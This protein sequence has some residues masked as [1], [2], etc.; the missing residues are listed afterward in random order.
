MLQKLPDALVSNSSLQAQ[1]RAGF[2]NSDLELTK[3]GRFALLEVLSQEYVDKLTTEANRVIV[4][5]EE[6][7]SN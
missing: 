6:D 3:A 4:E 2:R 1:Y 5:A 7:E